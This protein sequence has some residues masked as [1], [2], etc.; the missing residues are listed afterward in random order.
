MVFCCLPRC[1]VCFERAQ[2]MAET[3][4]ALS[5]ELRGAQHRAGCWR[6][7]FGCAHLDVHF[8]AVR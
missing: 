7:P 6:F 5:R 4:R 2:E 1:L 3:S 8:S